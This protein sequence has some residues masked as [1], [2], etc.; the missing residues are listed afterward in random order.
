MSGSILIADAARAARPVAAPGWW[1]RTARR[2]I[3]ARLG[4]LRSGAIR[5]R[6]D[7]RERMLG[8]PHGALGTV[9]LDVHDGSFWSALALGGDVAAGEAFVAGRWSTPDLVRLLRLFVRDRDVLLGV[10]GSLWSLP[11]RLLRRVAHR[12]RRNDHAG[13]RRNIAD[14][15]DLGDELFTHFLDPSLTYSSAWF[16][17][18][19][20][21]LADAQQHKL[22]R[23]C[24]LVDLQ[25]GDRLLEI[26]TG[27]GSLALCA[28]GEFGASVTTTT[29]SPN[30]F[31]AA[32]AR[33]QAAGL[34]AQVDVRRQDYRD[35][36]GTFD[37]VLSCEMIEAVGARY[38]PTYLR[39]CA[40]RLRPGGQLGLQAITIRDQFYDSALRTVDYIK[41]HVFPGSFIPSVTA[42]VGA[43]TRHTDLRPVQMQDFGPHY[44]TTLQHWREAIER[45]PAPF[46]ARDASGGLMRAWQYYFAYCESGFRERQLG[47]CHLRFE[48]AG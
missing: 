16:E 44:A 33:V 10:D 9:D 40:E 3:V 31:A 24:R 35:L 19:G 47:V 48:R 28:A 37:K 32:T 11:L 14:H 41:R 7:G 30:Q 8:D 29:I 17:H 22:R 34:A 15:Y 27:W 6:D 13:S 36:D 4:G 18:P 38:L 21:S 23:L 12:L 39:T 5:L 2:Q 26:G 43:A 20:Q 45:D 42:I 25:A 46:T 1:Q